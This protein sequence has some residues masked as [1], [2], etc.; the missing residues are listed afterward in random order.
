MWENVPPGIEYISIL[1]IAAFYGIVYS[2]FDREE[3][4]FTS[5]LDPFYFSLVTMSTVGYGDFSPKT[6]NAKIVTMTQHA[7]MLVSSMS[8]VLKVIGLKM[9]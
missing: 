4:G 2:L 7:L 6:T 1:M 5:K 8:V 9:Y 3:F